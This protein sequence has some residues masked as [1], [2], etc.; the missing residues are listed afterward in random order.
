MVTAGGVLG[1]VT[2]MGDSF[3]HVEIA[4]GVKIKVQRQTIGAVMPKGTFKNA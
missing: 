1:K 4:D 2:E 3:V